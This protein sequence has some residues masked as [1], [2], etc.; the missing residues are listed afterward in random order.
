M[1][2]NAKLY[3]ITDDT[4]I[5]AFQILYNNAPSDLK[6]I[7]DNTKEI[8]QSPMWHSEG[9]VYIHTKLV[10][11]RLHNTY[12]DINLTLSGLFHDL[13]KIETTIWNEVKETWSAH[14]HEDY[15]IILAEKYNNWISLN[16]GDINIVLYIIQNHMRIKFLDE[17]RI[18]EKIK[19]L[20]NS[21]FHYVQKFQTAD[22]GGF[23]IN[24]KDEIDLT[25]IKKEIQKYKQLK[26]EKKIISDKFNGKIIMELYP[27]LKGKELGNVIHAFKNKFSD[28]TNYALSMNKEQIISDFK[29]FYTNK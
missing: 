10:T 9:D 12:H 29:L 1:N 4:Y 25:I 22:Y 15:S 28:F 24:C 16:N 2:D 18:Q 8:K 19:F 14:G 11:N 7:L 27:T 17:F 23:N 20:D 6:K 21:L 5:D 26:I 3:T 13:G